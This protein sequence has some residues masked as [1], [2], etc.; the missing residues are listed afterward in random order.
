MIAVA[1]PE[2]RPLLE[3]YFERARKNK[4][5]HTPHDLRTALSFHTNFDETGS[6]K[7]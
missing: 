1:H 6:M 3:E 7:G 4:F 2:Y 5:Q